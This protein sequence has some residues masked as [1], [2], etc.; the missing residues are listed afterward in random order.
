M[1]DDFAE[2]RPRLNWDRATGKLEA[3]EGARRI[4][5]ISGG[6]IPDRGLFGVFLAG[7]GRGGARVGE[8]DE[9]MVFESR[10]GE[11]FLLGAST[12][13]IEEI[14]H[15]RVLVTPAPGEPGKM[16]F[17]R[18]ESAGRTV[19]LGRMIGALTREVRG[20]PRSAARATL[21]NRHSLDDRAADNLLAYL[22][23]QA[24]ATEVVPDD[25]HILIERCRDELGD[26]RVC[27]LSPLGGR[28]HAPWAMAVTAK[29]RAELG[30]EVETMWTDD[31][32]VVRL[33]ESDEAPD[34]ALV[35]PAPDELE[36]LVLRQ[37]GSSA[38][39]AAKFREAAARALLLPRRFP[40]RRAPLWQTRKKAAD[41]LAAASRQP[42]FP[43][44]LEAYRECLRDVFDL[45]AVTEVL[46]GIGRGEIAVKTVT[47]PVPSPFASGVLFGYVANY[48]YDG[49]APL[50]ERRAQALTVDEGL[51]RE[52]LG[53]AELRELLDPDCV[54]SVEEE[55]QQLPERLRARSADGVHDLLLRLGDLDRVEIGRRSVDE[56]V[57]ATID[58]LALARRAVELT[59]AGDR[60]FVAAEHVSRYRDGLGAVLPPGLPEAFRR[61][62]A[63]PLGDLLLRYARTHGP[64]A[65]TAPAQRLGLR[66]AD[67][68]PVLHRLAAENKLVEGAF[69]R[70][71]TEREWCDPE[72]LRNIRRRS[73]ARLRKE[74]EPVEPAVLARL[75]TRWQ[76]VTPGERRAGLD[77]LLD[78]VEKLQ[79]LP[80]PASALERDV[81]PARIEGYLPGDLD[82]L[83]AAGEIVWVGV[84][85]LGARD[86]RVALFLTDQLNRLH[87]PR[88][89][90]AVVLDPREQEVLGYLDAQ[91][92]SFF[93][94]IHEGTGGGF[95]QRTVDTLWSLVWKGLV[96][97]D[98]FRAL[99][100]FAR[101]TGGG[102]R[103]R[104]GRDRPASGG[105]PLGLPPDR[106]DRLGYSVAFRSRRA[107]PAAAEGRWSL[108]SSRAR[109][110]GGASD[111]ERG[112]S[113][114]RAAAGAS[115]TERAAALARQLL[116]RY[117]L[118]TR[119]VGAAEEIPGGF[120]AVYEVLR[121][122]EETGKIRRGYFVAGVAAMQFALPP[123]LEMLR[124]LRQ[125]PEA[126]EV[127]TLLAVDP[128]NPYGAILPWPAYTG[129]PQAG[130][131]AGRLRAGG[132]AG[133]DGDGAGAGK[134]GRSGEGA[135]AE[136][137]SGRRG[138]LRAAGTH[139]VLVD[140]A[141]AAWVGR[142]G[143]QLLTF[144][145]A[146]EP[147]RSRVAGALATA[148]A[149]LAGGGERRDRLI[150]AQIDDTPAAQH[151]LA[152]ALTAAG[153]SPV[154][155]GLQYR[156]PPTPRPRAADA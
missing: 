45:P 25:R 95:P 90:A 26:W 5:V 57:A 78:A 52:L 113:R 9:E 14:T 74:V 101:G 18:G 91:G 54:T 16:P 24:D 4:A 43:M 133:A 59:V 154:Y 105:V 109:A 141:L 103:G 149:R 20:L 132:R 123:V 110:T 115:D 13:R 40:G 71:H 31:G 106:A 29:M 47:S 155:E 39:F 8:L 116:A 62:S 69:L 28:V 56:T 128:A 108:V 55:L 37:L 41:L 145:P 49:D 94:A 63:D 61:P 139:V 2:L 35:L 84:S 67:V 150:V 125:R 87:L 27:V 22:R 68:E 93:A 98:T 148:L 107:A 104:R 112:S 19:E 146:E 50:A 137:G 152:E 136:A 77:A 127:V 138:P 156:P 36:P 99:R 34:P 30:L 100:A 111:T 73:L 142:G 153:F 83:A 7:A 102:A 92:A 17:W 147:D 6:T 144:L 89:R 97:N 79:G 76:G 120:S 117:G 3:R 121:T 86:G 143:R 64:F 140:G 80:L 33:P 131:R 60:R 48:I 151:P 15:D 10:V 65:A 122:M 46:R 51:L 82:S 96:T 12:W 32:F 134:E 21:V 38:L 124:N 44:L 129:E 135:E 126:P 119:E 75:V 81:L 88:D 1:S 53:E 72:V 70:G 85:P 58:G 118:V 11:T 130:S 23:D 42:S 114:A 66:P